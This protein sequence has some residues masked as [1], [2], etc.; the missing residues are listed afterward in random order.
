EPLLSEGEDSITYWASYGSAHALIR[1]HRAEEALSLLRKIPS[2]PFPPAPQALW[3][4]AQIAWE[5]KLLDT[6]R[7]AL[8]RLL[9][10]SLPASKRSEAFLWLAEFHA[11]ENQ[12]EQALH[13][14]DSVSS[15]PPEPR[16]R[17]LLQAAFRALAEKN[18]SAAESLFQKSATITGPHTSVAL[19][20]RAEAL[21]RNGS[22]QEAVSAY[23]T[24]LKHPQSRESPYAAEA[25]LA[26]AWIYLQ[27]NQPDEALRYSE[28]L[29]KH[30]QKEIQ[31]YATFISASALYLK[32]RYNESLSLY[33]DI[34]PT[35]PRVR[36]HLAQTLL[37]LERYREAESILAEANPTA[38]GADAML[39]LR[40]E[41]CAV[42]L[43]RPECTREAAATLLRHFPSSPWAPSARARLGLALA[44]IGEKEAAIQTLQQVIEGPPPSTEAA[45]LAL[46][47][48][49]ALLSASAYDSIYQ[50][51]LRRLPVESETRLSFE[52]DRLRQLADA[53]KWSL[54]Q[55][56][57]I[58][59]KTRYPSLTA[60]ALSWQALAAEHLKDTAQ[61]LSLYRELTSYAE[62]S[63]TAWEKLSRLYQAQG[64]TMEAW[65]AQD[66]FLHRLPT[67][68]YL[69]VQG[70]L[71]WAELAE[72]SG[73]AD[74]AIRI[75]R[76][77]L[78]DTLLGA[79]A[80]QRTLLTLA[81]LLEKNGQ[82]DSA[83]SYLLPIPSLEKNVI[84]A[85]ALYRQARILY[86]Q[87]KNNEARS[88]IYRLRDEMPAYVEPRGRAYLLLAR[89]FLTE[90]KR[91]SARQ[92]LESLIENAPTEAIRR[93]AQA[94]KETIPPD[95]PPDPSKPKNKKKKGQSQ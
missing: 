69:R 12:F 84:A 63:P 48:L 3:L 35:L 67:S 1:L 76:E 25:R 68:G 4:S 70:L 83:L 45:R 8:Y 6:G 72:S 61:A 19:F 34:L 95:P 77:L 2:S 10:L 58:R 85:E 26:I 81:S 14:L 75:C 22:L 50:N 11:A 78:G 30:T 17:F 15:P 56:A 49:R 24:F 71:T 41:I 51:F 88:A 18:F 93:E 44:E 86:T 80:R 87:G 13:L 5:L 55:E 43:N 92:L 32:K 46:E 65:A 90:N 37:R 16:Q 52:R 89:I 39:Y 74:T 21:Y 42:W 36:Y 57:A 94:L 29:R 54:L 40:A 38:P 79:F 33:R 73:R 53:E 23:Q 31:S 9:K 60:E 66:S 82:L 28:P 91:K 47:G 27:L 7:E 59:L 62:L 20:W 64:R